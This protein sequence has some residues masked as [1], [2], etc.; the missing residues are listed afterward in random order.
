MN[1]LTSKI[2]LDETLAE[3]DRYVGYIYGNE[4]CESLDPDIKARLESEDEDVRNQMMLLLLLHCATKGAYPKEHMAVEAD[5]LNDIKNILYY[6]YE[7]YRRGNEKDKEKLKSY[8]YMSTDEGAKFMKEQLNSMPYKTLQY[9]YSNGLTLEENLFNLKA[10]TAAA[11]IYL[12]MMNRYFYNAVSSD[13]DINM[14]PYMGKVRTKD[15]R[16]TLTSKQRF[17]KWQRYLDA[18]DKYQNNTL[19]K[20]YDEVRPASTTNVS[21]KAGSA[22]SDVEYARKLI[23]AAEKG[24]FPEID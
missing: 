8:K 2:K 17:E 11:E 22:W 1:K 6:R 23:L 13:S 15:N 5:A 4:Y 3:F 24:T 10:F 20:V 16:V 21:S 19:E 7:F 18:F 9:Q 12:T 14:K